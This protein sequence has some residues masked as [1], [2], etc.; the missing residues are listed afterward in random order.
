LVKKALEEFIKRTKEQFEKHQAEVA[1]T[2][3][4]GTSADDTEF[5]SYLMNAD[6]MSVRQFLAS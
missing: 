3:D 2:G 5:W 4:K 1:R 6:N